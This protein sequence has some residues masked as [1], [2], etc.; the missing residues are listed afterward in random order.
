MVLMYNKAHLGWN[1]WAEMLEDEKYNPTSQLTAGSPLPCPDRRWR[2]GWSHGRESA[3]ETALHHPGSPA[4]GC[5]LRN[6]APEGSKS[7]IPHFF[8]SAFSLVMQTKLKNLE[9]SRPETTPQG[10]EGSPPRRNY[11]SDWSLH[12]A[13]VPAPF[14][15]TLGA[16]GRTVPL[17]QQSWWREF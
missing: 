16:S 7:D 5:S 11:P 3:P 12:P 10:P 14:P 9:S 2:Q 15:G 8:P 17:R 6:P 1:W 4:A 13:A